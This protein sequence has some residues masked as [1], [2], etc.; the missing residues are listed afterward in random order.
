LESRGGECTFEGK[1]VFSD[2]GLGGDLMGVDAVSESKLFYTRG[3]FLPEKVRNSKIVVCRLQKRLRQS[4][5]THSAIYLESKHIPRLLRDI[6]FAE[7]LEESRIILWITQDRHAS[8]ILC[9]GTKKGD[10][11]DINFLDGLFNFDKRLCNGFLEGI[12]VADDI[13]NL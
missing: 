8:M 12:E 10:A 13:I 6:A 2:V 4:A 9:S 7:F 5:P 1:I 3:I 11:A